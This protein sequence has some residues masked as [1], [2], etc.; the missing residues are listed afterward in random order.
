MYA[1][2]CPPDANDITS[3]LYHVTCNHVFLSPFPHLEQTRLA[4]SYSMVHQVGLM[5]DW[6]G[7][8]NNNVFAQSFH[9]SSSSV[10]GGAAGQGRQVLHGSSGD[11]SGG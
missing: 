11:I 5:G 3:N 10:G 6:Q 2:L 7:A 8:L 4:L 9:G 1:C